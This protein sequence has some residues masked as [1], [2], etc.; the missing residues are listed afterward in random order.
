MYLG[1]TSTGVLEQTE[2]GK[3]FASDK[4]KLMRSTPPHQPTS[5]LCERYGA[6]FASDFHLPE[7]GLGVRGYV[8]KVKR[9]CTFG[10]R[11]DATKNVKSA[12]FFPLFFI[13]T[14]FSGLLRLIPWA[15][16]WSPCFG[17]TKIVGTITQPCK[18]SNRQGTRESL[19]GL[20]NQYRLSLL[21]WHPRDKGKMSL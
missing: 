12:P 17:L 6:I 11:N 18:I 15:M 19:H 10:F 1:S 2:A 16:L 14:L 13:L 20:I 3:S 9:R 7:A 4:H 21:Q 8:M 5:C